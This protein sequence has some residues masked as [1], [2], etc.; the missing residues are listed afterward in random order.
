MLVIIPTPSDRQYRNF[1]DNEVHS[2]LLGCPALIHVEFAQFCPT[3][4][5]LNKWSEIGRNGLRPWDAPLSMLL[6]YGYRGYG[7]ESNFDPSW[8][9]DEIRNAVEDLGLVWDIK[10]LG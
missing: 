3:F 1:G 9:L 4:G 5:F 6:T 2:I 10:A 8:R 7:F